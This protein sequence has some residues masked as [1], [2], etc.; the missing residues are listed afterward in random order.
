MSFESYPESVRN[1]TS[2]SLCPLQVM[3]WEKMKSE[4]LANF[5]IRSRTKKIASIWYISKLWEIRRVKL[6][7]TKQLAS[8]IL[9]WPLLKILSLHTPSATGQWLCLFVCLSV[10]LSVCPPACLS[11]CLS[12]C[13]SICPPA[14]L[15]VCLSVSLSACQSVWM[16]ESLSVCPLFGRF[17]SLSVGMSQVRCKAQSRQY[18]VMSVPEF[19]NFI[20][21]PQTRGCQFLN[22]YT[23][24][25]SAV[26]AN[27]GKSS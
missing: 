10:C 4:I 23:V 19:F 5:R 14:C 27:T 16:H 13:L 2:A 15:P 1:M 11:V 9:T 7:K 21:T 25:W 8:C 26:W 20:D 22:A 12:V 24:N 6:K 17:L 18:W 3:F